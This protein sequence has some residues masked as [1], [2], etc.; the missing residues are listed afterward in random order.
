MFIDINGMYVFLFFSVMAAVARRLYVRLHFAGPNRMTII[1]WSS[2]AI[3][4]YH[5]LTLQLPTINVSLNLISNY[6]VV[7]VTMYLVASY[8]TVI[9]KGGVG[10]NGST[11]AV[12]VFEL[13]LC[14]FNNT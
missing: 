3:I 12:R 8:V 13:A 6:A 10:K 11:V 5:G 9:M 2:H 1:M 14:P 7:L 4:A